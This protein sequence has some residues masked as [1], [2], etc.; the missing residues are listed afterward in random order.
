MNLVLRYIAW[1]DVMGTQKNLIH[2][3]HVTIFLLIAYLFIKISYK[4]GDITKGNFK[5]GNNEITVRL[6]SLKK[7]LVTHRACSNHAISKAEFGRSR[8]VCRVSCHKILQT[9]ALAGTCVS[10]GKITDGT[11]LKY[12]TEW[13]LLL[14][15][16]KFVL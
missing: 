10:L 6:Q 15:F 5:V 4:T 14:N 13:C 7:K 8:S 11:S 2:V 12:A 9:A 1:E 16:L 3:Q